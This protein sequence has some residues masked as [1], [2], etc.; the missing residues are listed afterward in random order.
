MLQNAL[1][2]LALFV[3]RQDVEHPAKLPQVVLHQL[4]VVVRGR[5]FGDLAL[6][7][8]VLRGQGLSENAARMRVD[9][10]LD[11]LRAALAK[12]GVTS[13]A[14]ALAA[15]LAE[16]A[17]GAAPAGLAAHVSH[18]AFAAG[19]AA[20][21]SLSAI[22]QL[23]MPARIHL[24]LST[25]VVAILVTGPVW[26]HYAHRHTTA[27]GG[28]VKEQAPA[29]SNRAGGA[30]GTSNL[31][32]AVQA[33]LLGARQNILRLRVVAD[34]TGKPIPRATLE[35]WVSE[36]GR[37]GSLGPA[38]PLTATEAGACAVPLAR[39]T[40]GFV[41]IGSRTDGFVDTTFAWSP[42]RGEIIPQEYTLRLRPAVPI[43]GRVVDT[44]GN[45][46]AGAEVK[47][48]VRDAL[49]RARQT[50]ENPGVF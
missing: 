12:R 31:L 43:G 18:A 26:F 24:L 35:Y 39:D 46:V 13:T 6:Q 7:V 10:A 36:K 45:P 16:R 23:L 19:A 5:L 30:G 11:K 48:Q 41:L 49:E 15:V 40:A 9:R 2:G 4:R 29:Q 21:G 14:T 42:D 33:P 1:Q 25:A 47:L 50:E 44:E 34:D 22:S 38:T 3:G 17:I 28:E 8:G 32:A 27:P 20:S 37:H